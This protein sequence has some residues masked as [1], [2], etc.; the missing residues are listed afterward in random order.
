MS[1]KTQAFLCEVI[2]CGRPGPRGKISHS[3]H[4][5]EGHYRR[6]LRTGEFSPE[7]PLAPKRP[8]TT[9]CAV[10]GCPN[11]TGDGGLGYCSGHY[12]RLAIHGDL[13]ECDPIIPRYDGCSVEGCDLVHHGK[14]YCRTHCARFERH[15]H[16][17]AD[18]PIRH[19]GQPF[20]RADGY[21]DVRRNGIVKRQHRLVMEQHLGRPLLR[22][23]S[24]HH[25]NGVRD[26]NRIQNLELWSSSQP[27]GQR[28]VDK[29]AWA[30]EILELY[31]D[32]IKDGL[33]E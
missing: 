11:T 4:L 27:S 24:V 16:P 25:K 30:R 5:C 19:E 10:D 28:I 31:V 8:S 26:D 23:E 21:V 13:R 9:P 3:M 6:L 12:Q 20:L 29:V 7:K 33:I 32:D 17:Q 14:G 18:I 22:S 15:G 2:G 1:T